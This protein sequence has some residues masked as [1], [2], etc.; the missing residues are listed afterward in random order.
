MNGE[1]ILEQIDSPAY[2]ILSSHGLL[3]LRYRLQSPNEIDAVQANSARS[4]NCLI[5]AFC[6]PCCF[7]YKT[8]EV[9][10]AQLQLVTDGRGGYDFY[11][12]G[13]HLI[14]DPFHLLGKR[15]NFSKGA[16]NHGDLNLVVVEQGKIGYA[17]D[18]GHPILL[19]P[20]LHQWRSPT[21]VFEKAFDLNNNVIRM[22]PLTLV[23]VDSGY[24]AVT[25]DNG[26]QKILSGGSTYLLTHRNWKFQKYIPEKIQV[27]RFMHTCYMHT[28]YMYTYY[29]YTY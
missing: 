23:T 13:V 11:G 20:G 2:Q 12:K 26:E 4:T 29:M 27:L 17:S 28:C 1:S 19:P 7:M 18:Q 8:F 5:N 3:E 21:M 16:I 25:E 14:C 24:A 9:N 10:A 22:G 15:V 6:F